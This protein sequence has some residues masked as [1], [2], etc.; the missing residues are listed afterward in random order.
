ISQ[1]A[2][3]VEPTAGSAA[4]PEPTPGAAS[5]TYTFTNAG[6]YSV[7]LTVTD[8]CGVAGTASQVAGSNLLV[9]V[10]LPNNPPVARCKN[11]TVSAGANCM[12]DASIDNG[13]F[14]PDAGDTITLTQTPPGPYPLGSTGVT[15]TV[16]DNHGA[17]NTCF[18][19]VTVIDT[20][21]PSIT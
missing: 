10:V 2:T 14:D 4:S 6:V 8:S 18:S 16:T 9:T 17:S 15:L 7:K 13:S 20:T 12:A 19:R 5:A 1:T 3:I 21:P 11:V